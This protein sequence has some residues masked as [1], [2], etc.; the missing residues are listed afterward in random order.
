MSFNVGPFV[1]ILGGLLLATG[2]LG[3]AGEPS[4]R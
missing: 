2:A 4:E 1:G 3:L